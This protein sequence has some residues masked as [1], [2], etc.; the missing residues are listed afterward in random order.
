MTPSTLENCRQDLAVIEVTGADAL[1]FLQGQLSQDLAL[2]SL[3]RSQLGAWADAAGRI[4][5]LFR[6]VGTDTGFLLATAAAAAAPLSAALAR[7]VL[8]A[9]VRITP[10]DELVA[11]S[12]DTAPFIQGAGAAA[13]WLPGPDSGSVTAMGGVIAVR[14]ESGAVLALGH[15]AELA[16]TL[17]AAGLSPVAPAAAIAAEIRAAVPE[18]TPDLGARYIPQQLNLDRLGAL[19]FTKGCYPGQEIVARTHHLGTVKRR[20]FVF[21]A[22]G[23]DPAPGTAIVDAAGAEVGEVIRSAGQAGSAVMLAVVPVAAAD[24]ALYLAGPAGVPVQ[25]LPTAITDPATGA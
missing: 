3:D 5:G 17:A 4:R 15:A 9:Q 19:S 22:A 2:V 7:F 10:R 1:T 21:S 12:L 24:T 20:A 6:I 16:E 18:I 25:R 13:A 11:V 14:T 8:R 23:P